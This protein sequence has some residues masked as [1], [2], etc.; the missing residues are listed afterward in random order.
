MNLIVFAA[1][2]LKGKEFNNWAGFNEYLIKSNED[3]LNVNIFSFLNNC[4]FAEVLVLSPPKSMSLNSPGSK[5]ICLSM[6]I[7][8]IYIPEL[9]S[10]TL[11]SSKGHSG[12]SHS[13]TCVCD[14]FCCKSLQLQ[15]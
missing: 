12:A 5:T 11:N 7:K 14:Q 4:L 6:G 2:P 3:N 15:S 10:N 13:H 9:E 1:E 8:N